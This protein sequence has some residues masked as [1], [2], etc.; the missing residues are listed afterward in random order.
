MDILRAY[1]WDA[2]RAAAFA[3]LAA[4]G[5]FPARVIAEYSGEFRVVTAEGEQAAKLAGKLKHRAKARAE[6]PAVGDWVALTQPAVPGDLAVVT[7]VLPRRSKFSRAAAGER[8]EEQV[9]AANVDSVWIVVSA[10]VPLNPRRLERFLTLA[11]ESGAAPAC[12]LTKI[13]AVPDAAAVRAGLA[14]LVAGVPVHAVSNKTG[15]GLEA[16]RA[17]LAGDHTVALLGP[18]G[19]GKTSLLNRFAGSDAAVQEVRASDG[20]GRHTTTNRQL[21]RLSGGGLVVD[22]PG[23]RELQLWDA[24]EGLAAAFDDLAALALRCKFTNCRHAA[25]PGCA[26]HA[27]LEAGEVDAGRLASFRK[28]QAEVEAKSHAAD[29]RAEAEARRRVRTGQKEFAKGNPKR[30]P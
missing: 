30:R 24:A 18:S 26:V 29:P 1:G 12:V 23:M 14:A 17:Y 21:I 8:G 25:E 27:A 2:A 20:E 5:A 19:V 13:D 22:T 6:L 4:A 16:L 10:D 3:P 15:E 28:L 9:V 11:H 7:A